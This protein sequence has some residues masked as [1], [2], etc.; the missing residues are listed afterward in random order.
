MANRG[1]QSGHRRA[2]KVTEV[3]ELDGLIRKGTATHIIARKLGRPIWALHNRHDLARKRRGVVYRREEVARL[4]GVDGASVA[5]WQTHGWLPRTRNGAN[6]EQRA[7]AEQQSYAA[8]YKELFPSFE[9]EHAAPPASRKHAHYLLTDTAIEAFMANRA[10]WY[11]WD[12][13]AI[14]DPAWRSLAETLRAQSDGHWL[15]TEE[16]ADRV[17]CSVHTARVWHQK[18]QT[19]GLETARYGIHLYWWSEGL[20]QWTPPGD[21]LRLRP[22]SLVALRMARDGVTSTDLARERAIPLALAS[23]LLWLLLERGLLRRESD[24]NRPGRYCYWR[25]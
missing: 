5:A 9:G 3:R 22:S 15:T 6:Q 4:F 11:A 21:R 2:W 16:F 8:F 23:R 18:G 7:E 13:A 14:T 19:E 12:P 20:A 25:V 24:P 10:T 1:N 17:G